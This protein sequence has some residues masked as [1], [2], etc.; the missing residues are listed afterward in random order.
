[1]TRPARLCNC[2][3]IVPH[4]VICACQRE[5]TRARNRRHDARRPSSRERGYTR[6]WE[7]ARLDFLRHHPFCAMC[8][9]PSG[10]VDHVTPHRGDEALF[11]D[12]SNW[13]ALCA[14]CHNRHKQRLER[15]AAA[16]ADV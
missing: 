6:Q 15:A 2:G 11:W 5:A 13:Q 7:K 4:G 3:E 9:N 10:V 1:M 12:W 14:P 16:Q 8:G